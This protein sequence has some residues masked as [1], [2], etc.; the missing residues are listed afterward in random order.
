MG[1]GGGTIVPVGQGGE[2]SGNSET[3]R[4]DSETNSL[5]E[6]EVGQ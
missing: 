4:W 5:W 1:Q 2:T 6:K 3:K